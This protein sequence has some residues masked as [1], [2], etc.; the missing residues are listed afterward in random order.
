MTR[1]HLVSRSVHATLLALLACLL[2]VRAQALTFDFTTIGTVPQNVIDGFNQAGQLWSTALTDNVTVHI[3][4]GYTDLGSGI[5]GNTSTTEYFMSYSTYRSA[6]SSDRTS[7]YDFTAVAS[8]P[9]GSSYPVS[10]NYLKVGATPASATPTA[11]S[12]NQVII[13]QATM[14]AL[15]LSALS[16]FDASITFSSSFNFDFNR[17]DGISG[18]AYDFV[19]VAAHEIGH[20]LGF[21]SVVD[22]IDSYA[23]TLNPLQASSV[24]PTAFDLFRFTAPGVRSIA[25]GVSAYL[26]FDGGVTT[27][28][29]LATGTNTGDGR[30]AS[31][32]KD[33]LG[34]GLMDPTLAPGELEVLTTNDLK[35]F[36]IIGWNVA[37][38]IPEPATYAALLGASALALAIYRR[39]R[40]A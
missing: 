29:T 37:S 15:G 39:R 3:Q 36:D 21:T 35:A 12:S 26:S 28:G 10:Y 40:A 27:V 14:R 5:L 19:G 7:S 23:L 9:T 24:D 31:H 6:L 2:G 4:I 34:L 16:T 30:Q 1:C 8:L 25:A 20:A 33:N 13:S 32:W 22:T 38:F 17:A 18:G 11:D